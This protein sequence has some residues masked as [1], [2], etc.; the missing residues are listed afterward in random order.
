[1]ASHRFCRTYSQPVLCMLTEGALDSFG[2]EYVAQRSR[3]SV[4]VDVIDL[5]WLHTGISH[6]GD[7][8]AISTFALFC[9]LRNVI[10][11]SAHAV[12]DDLREDRSTAT[13][14]EFQFLENQ[15][16]CAFSDYE[17]VAIDIK[18]A[19]GFFRSIV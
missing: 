3:C 15:D 2:F 17:A 6:G 10:S 8:H 12:P 4:H 13:A 1:M 7:H 11:I 16:A 19:A 14:R 9:R 18:W 5:L